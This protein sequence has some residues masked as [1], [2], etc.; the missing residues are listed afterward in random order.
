M[1]GLILFVCIP[2]YRKDCIELFTQQKVAAVGLIGLSKVLFS[3]S[4]AV[5]LYATLLAPVA[6][7]LLVNSFQPLFVFILGIAL[8]LLLPR[9]ARESLDRMKMLQGSGNWPHTRRRLPDQPITRGGRAGRL[10]PVGGTLRA[11][12]P[13]RAN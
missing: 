4:E 8:T 12:D 13:Q 6:L 10:R 11:A 3:V 9:V 1:A 5:T 7:V 2:G